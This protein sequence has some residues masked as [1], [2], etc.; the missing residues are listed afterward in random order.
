VV[1]RQAQSHMIRAQKNKYTEN[2]ATK[3]CAHRSPKR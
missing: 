2:Q 3:R 1:V